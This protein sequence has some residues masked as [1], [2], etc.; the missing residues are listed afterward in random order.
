MAADAVKKEENADFNNNKNSLKIWEFSPV[1]EHRVASTLF[2][3]ILTHFPHLIFPS[4]LGEACK[5]ES[6]SY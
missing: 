1:S 5:A 4:V 6:K 3:V 2:Y